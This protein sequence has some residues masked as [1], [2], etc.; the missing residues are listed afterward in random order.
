MRWKPAIFDRSRP[1]VRATEWG[2]LAALV[3]MLIMFFGVFGGWRNLSFSWTEIWERNRHVDWSSFWGFDP[4]RVSVVAALAVWILVRFLLI[5]RSI[6]CEA[7]D[8]RAENAPDDLEAHRHDFF[9]LPQR[10]ARAAGFP[11]AFKPEPGDK[12]DG[13]KR[14]E[15]LNAF[16]RSSD[17]VPR[18]SCSL[19][20]DKESA[21]GNGSAPLQ[22]LGDLPDKLRAYLAQYVYEQGGTFQPSRV[23]AR[24]ME[25]F[26]NRRMDDLLKDGTL[27]DAI[28]IDETLKDLL[29]G[30]TDRFSAESMVQAGL[31]VQE[32]D[33]DLYPPTVLVR[34]APIFSHYD[35]DD[36]PVA[37][38]HS[39]SPILGADCDDM[40]WDRREIRR[41][42]EDNG[43]L[44][45]TSGIYFGAHLRSH[46]HHAV[47]IHPHVWAY[48]EFSGAWPLPGILTEKLRY[49]SYWPGG[50]KIDQFANWF[51]GQ[52]RA[53]GVRKVYY[54]LS[55]L[56]PAIMGDE[57]WT[58]RIAPRF[59]FRNFIGHY[60]APSMKAV[61]IEVCNPPPLLWTVARQP[62]GRRQKVGSPDFI[63]EHALHDT[64]GTS[65][66]LGISANIVEPEDLRIE[67]AYVPHNADSTSATAGIST[68]ITEPGKSQ[69]SMEGAPL[70]GDGT[71]ATQE[72]TPT[73]IAGTTIE[74][75]GASHDSDL[76]DHFRGEMLQRDDGKWEVVFGSER[77]TLKD[78]V[79]LRYMAALF[80]HPNDSI[81]AKQLHDSFRPKNAP[82]GQ[83]VSIENVSLS[84]SEL[85]Q[86][87]ESD[88]SNIGYSIAHTRISRPCEM[89]YSAIPAKKRLNYLKKMIEDKESDIEEA[90]EENKLDPYG[91]ENELRRTIA[92]LRAKKK[93]MEEQYRILAAECED[94]PIVKRV[95]KALR[96]ARVQLEKSGLPL[97]AQYMYSTLAPL[98]SFKIGF[99]PA[100]GDPSDLK[101]TIRWANQD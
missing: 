39:L 11:V 87:T 68:N 72:K 27:K 66:I 62:W 16:I 56:F 1:A 75:M 78:Y 55:P 86:H 91:D 23:S 81:D 101:W 37:L 15:V 9:G 96:D 47:A 98:E 70:D 6:R 69:I 10:L 65:V 100:Y 67:T 53:A 35:Q 4:L 84:P 43:V 28:S 97:L 64:D 7:L 73:A 32:D 2:A 3:V 52:L 48:P 45:I 46:L 90:R 25:W 12:R 93:S 88:E 76:E 95:G 18:H 80:S 20:W 92:G 94:N 36:R 99:T 44:F 30:L 34:D 54:D 58:H 41:A 77:G 85:D 22:S 21:E 33:H 71:A 74:T 42:G 26:N 19:P 57:T 29:Q 63:L 14:S 5:L 49:G 82:P 83:W 13:G 8:P 79:G 24:R 51:T 50:Q 59:L 61:G 60:L 38:S 31:L 40:V 89:S 17:L